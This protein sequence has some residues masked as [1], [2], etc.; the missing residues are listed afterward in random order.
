MIGWFGCIL[1]YSSGSHIN[2]NVA[3][4][5][6]YIISMQ[7]VEALMW[8]DQKCDGLNQIASKIGFL[9]NI[10]QPIVIFIALLPFFYKN[11]ILPKI[12]LGIYIITLLIF[13]TKNI[14]SMKNDKFWCTKSGY[15][16]LQW[17]WSRKQDVYVWITFI[18]S[19]AASMFYSKLS[20]FTSFAMFATLLASYLRYGTSKAVG[21]WWCLYAVCLPY[22]QLLTQ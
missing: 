3:L 1:L 14:K 12:M 11:N 17:N 15:G 13:I 8:M 10:G 5:F 19:F 22:V 16:G 4:M 7:L 9:Q 21:S 6:A 2:R 18:A 20:K